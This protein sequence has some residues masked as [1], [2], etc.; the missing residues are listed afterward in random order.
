MAVKIFIKRRVKEGKTGQAIEM[1]KRLRWDALNQPGY[2][3]G[4][5]LVDHY[6]SRNITVISMWKTVEDWI[7]WQES[8]LREANE[9]RF[10]DILELPTKYEVYNVER[11]IKE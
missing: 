4:E 2:I 1:L 5:T 3:S 6:D 7:R 10:S 11:Y 8:E 9:S